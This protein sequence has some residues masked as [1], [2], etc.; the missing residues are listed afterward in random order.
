MSQIL[1]DIH[2]N[3][4]FTMLYES[5]LSRFI[6]YGL[7]PEIG[8]D[9]L[10]LDCFAPADFKTVAEQIHEKG[11]SITMHAPFIDLSPGSPDPEVRALTRRRFQQFAELVPVFQPKAVVCHTGWDEKRYW[12]LRDSWIQYSLEL[13]AWL[14]EKVAKEGAF[15]I[16]ENVYERHPDEF[17]EVFKYLKGQRVGFCM[18]T[19]HQAVFSHVSLFVWLEKLGSRIVQLHLHDNH[20]HYDDHL[21]LGQGKIDFPMLFSYYKEKKIRQPIITLEPHKEEDLW[22]S[23]KYLEGVWP[24]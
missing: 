21:A 5:Y 10:S 15:L 18:D 16:L 19:G 8:F 17:E 24:W 13:W 11:L 23:V 14:E 12:G 2:V 6:Q 9:A 20:G 7:N 22:P 3:I 1:N 4:P